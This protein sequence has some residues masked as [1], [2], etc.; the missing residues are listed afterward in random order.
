ME[1]KSKKSL[2][3]ACFVAL[4][5]TSF[6]F[7]LRA[8]LITEWGV[9]FN[10]TKTQMGEIM[11][12]G[13]WPFFVSIVLFSLIIDKIGYGWAM[14]I[15]FIC[16]ISSLVITLLANGYWMLYIGT[17]IF[18]LGNGTVEAT[19]NPAVATMF[20]K[21]KTKWINKLHA[22]WPAGM[23]VGG[24]IAISFGESMRWQYKVAIILIPMLL[25]GIMMLNKKFPVQERVAAGVSYKDMLKELGII[26]ALIIISLIVFEIGSFFNLPLMV[27]II[28]IIL[29]T[30]AFGFYVRV[31]GQPVFIFLLLIMFP[32]ATTE[33][34]TDSWIVDLMANEMKDLHLQ[35]GWILV[36][37]ALIMTVARYFAGPAIKKLKPSG[38][39]IFSSAVAAVGLYFL[40]IT[41]GVIIFIAATIYGFAKSYLWPTMIG[42]VGE[43]FPKGGALTLNVTTGVGMMAVGIV[44]AVFLGF[45][46]DKG[47][48][49]NIANYD[50]FNRTNLKE[51]YITVEKNSIFGTYYT[52][53]TE[54]YEQAPVQERE[55]IENSMYKAKKEALKTVAILP[56]IM[57]LA[58]ITLFLFFKKEGGY[59][60]V[61]LNSN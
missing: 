26:G 58:F 7:M 36:Y 37:T 14:A 53:D 11:G 54:Q 61:E 33:L 19:I 16:H 31:P 39:L 27:K 15:A 60:P 48:E 49:H 20:S 10:L 29:L 23:V 5:A 12:V 30:G 35:P 40:S 24:I 52:L 25:Y 43:R 51:N 18:A 9:E 22:G 50:N 57:L 59:K 45:V 42:I 32:L 47:I 38:L 28:L 4:M 2:F 3:Y 41:T 55:I 6:G 46:Q 13:L 17:L 1:E 56:V 34:G 21:E 8:M 44:G